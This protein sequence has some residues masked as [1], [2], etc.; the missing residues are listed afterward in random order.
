MYMEKNL[1]DHNQ[2]H[3][4]HSKYN[5]H[6]QW[7]ADENNMEVFFCN[8]PTAHTIYALKANIG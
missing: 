6:V 4:N 2:N 5:E 8:L 7:M 1:F 3:F